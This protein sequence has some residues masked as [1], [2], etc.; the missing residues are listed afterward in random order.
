M[1][2]LRRQLTALETGQVSAR[3]LV[4]RT[5][6][7]ITST[8][9]DLNAFRHV[10]ADAA[11]AEADEADRRRAAGEQ[12]PLLGVPVAIKD[13]IDLA[14]A[15]TTFGCAGAFPRKDDDCEAVRRLKAAGAIIVGKTTTPEIGQWPITEGPAFGTTRNPWN[16]DHTPGGSSGGAAA[17][18][19]AGIVPVALGSDAAGSIRIPAAW[20]HLVGIKPQRGRIPTWPDVSACHGLTALGP[21]ARTVADAALLLD[22]IIGDR[23]APGGP[24][25]PPRSFAACAERDPGRLRIAVSLRIPFSGHPARLDPRIGDAV[26]SLAATLESLGHHVA[27]AD[28]DYGLAG[29]SFLPRATGGVRDWTRHMPRPSTLDRRTRAKVTSARV[30]G[31]PVLRMARAIERPLQRRIGRIFERH[32]VVLAPTTAQPAPRVGSIDGLGTRATDKLIIAAC[33]YAWPWNVVG[34]PAVN[35]P[36]GVV[37]DRLPV[38]ATLLGPAGGEPLLISLAAQLETARAW[39]RHSP[40]TFPASELSPPD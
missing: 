37:G 25:H 10:R 16:L 2:H 17:A 36:A 15:P 29:L 32:D 35:V 28:P 33:P 21:L 8:Q 38:G 6:D 5:L 14:G 31:G 39:H 1:S 34:W 13:D 9:A 30:L 23:P 7:A 18:V 40:P 4:Q 26:D 3:D 24:P 20:T 19:A 22:A 27:Y 11:L 12:A